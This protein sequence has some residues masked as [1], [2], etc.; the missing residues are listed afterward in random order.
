[1]HWFGAP[2]FPIRNVTGQIAEKLIQN[3]NW[4]EES[5]FLR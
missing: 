4:N 1:M 2:W 5:I 3:V